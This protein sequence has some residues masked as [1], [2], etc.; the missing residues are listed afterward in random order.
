M[1][2]TEVKSLAEQTSGATERIGVEIVAMQEVVRQ[3]VEALGGIAKSVD[4]VKSTVHGVTAGAEEQMS[5]TSGVVSNMRQAQSGVE[6]INRN[7]E[8]MLIRAR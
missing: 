8:E 6:A 7:L 4:S 2:A 1:V 5:L 3:V